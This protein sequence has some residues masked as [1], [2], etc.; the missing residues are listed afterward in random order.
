VQL[1][2][3]VK[4]RHCCISGTGWGS[5]GLVGVVVAAVRLKGAPSSRP[6]QR[7]LSPS[8][9]VVFLRIEFLVTN[10]APGAAIPRFA[11][12]AFRPGQNTAKLS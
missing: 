7:H 2:K 12:Q 9:L 5:A 3:R 8:G 10:T 11:R 1:V 4:A 6:E